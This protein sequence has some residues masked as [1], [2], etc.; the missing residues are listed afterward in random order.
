[1]SLWK[2]LLT[3]T[4]H[5][6]PWQAIAEKLLDNKYNLVERARK[7][8]YVSKMSSVGV[9][10]SENTMPHK[11]MAVHKD[12]IRQ[13]ATL[14]HEGKTGCKVETPVGSQ[15]RIV[16]R[17]WWRLLAH[18]AEENSV[19][20]DINLHSTHL[21]HSKKSADEI[22]NSEGRP[23]DARQVLDDIDDALR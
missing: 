14:S 10:V 2:R 15:E 7:G 23:L 8:E 21:N 18:Y 4:Y 11:Q 12:I 13:N 5:V 19:S 9:A 16:L 20:K 17:R 3:S 1:M 22:K 6:L